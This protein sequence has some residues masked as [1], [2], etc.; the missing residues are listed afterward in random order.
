MGAFIAVIS[1]REVEQMGR[2]ERVASAGQIRVRTCPAI[3]LRRLDHDGGYRV[4]LDVAHGSAGSAR[5]AL[6]RI[7]SVLATTHRGACARG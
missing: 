7:W 6:G 2:D 3:V 5:F 4:E 1:R